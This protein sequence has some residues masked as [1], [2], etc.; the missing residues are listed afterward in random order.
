MRYSLNSLLNI[1]CLVG[2][3]AACSNAGT[4]MN[5]GG[6]QTPTGGT[7][8]QAGTPA[9]GNT[10]GSG[11]A[12]KTAT[13]TGTAGTTTAPQ[14][15]TGGKPTS[16]AGGGAGGTPSASGGTG[17][18]A[19]STSVGGGFAMCGNPPKEGSCKQTAPGV[20]A[21]RIDLDVWYMDE[22]N[23][24]QPVFDPGR[25]TLTL[26]FRTELSNVCEDGTGGKAVNHPCGSVQP[27]LFVDA[28]GGVIQLN[29]PDELWDKPGIPDYIST[30]GTTGF[31]PGDTLTI[32]KTSG[33]FGISLMDPNGTWPTFME[34]T[35]VMCPEGTGAMCYP[36]V[37]GD[38]NP[39]VTLK[40]PTEG[41]TVP[42][43]G[44]ETALGW[45]FAAA[46]TSFTDGALGIGATS[47]YVGLRVSAGGSG[48]IGDDCKSGSGAG[49]VNDIESRVFDCVMADGMKCQSSGVEFV[50]Q[51]TPAF[52]VLKVDE[53][54]PAKWKHVR[55]E[56][57]MKLN[58]APSKGALAYVVRLGDV[59]QSFGCADIR[60]APF[61]MG[62]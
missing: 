18:S 22:V 5:G 42:N 44:Y 17:G 12:G 48:K 2:L 41:A 40:I 50:D 27:P 29:F 15:G 9:P 33:L 61:P 53:A 25:G 55:P 19:P 8:S 52:H 6:Q 57:D 58:R 21:Q 23:T 20:Y 39:G 24:S 51:N 3:A 4:A 36:D 38:G 56:A 26:W 45:H 35:S 13:G 34:T 7:T 16:T 31:N 1:G 43:P 60:N 32:A 54:P 14:G 49:D 30:G 46:P 37:D 10:G 62:N 11:T 28:N 47:V 59:G